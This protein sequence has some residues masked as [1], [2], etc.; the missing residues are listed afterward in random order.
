MKGFARLI[1][2]ATGQSY[3]ERF[4]AVRLNEETQTTKGPT[5]R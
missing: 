4:S 5:D 1:T 3:T 2:A